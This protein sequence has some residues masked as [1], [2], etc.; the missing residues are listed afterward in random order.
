LSPFKRDHNFY[1]N[2]NIDF[3]ANAIGW[4]T[5]ANYQTGNVKK[6]FN[7][8]FRNTSGVSLILDII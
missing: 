4:L 5:G 2:A 3:S 8:P 6:I 7:T 1:F